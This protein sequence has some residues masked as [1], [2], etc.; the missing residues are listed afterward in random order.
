MEICPQQE[1][2]KDPPLA[3]KHSLDLSVSPEITLVGHVS[4]AVRFRVASPPRHSS[5]QGLH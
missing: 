3:T 1:S 5:A 4:A 2:V